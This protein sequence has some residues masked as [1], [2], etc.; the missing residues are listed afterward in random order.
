M[1]LYASAANHCREDSVFSR[2]LRGRTYEALKRY[3]DAQA[4]Y[5]RMV[6]LA[7]EKAESGC[8][9]PTSSSERTNRQAISDIEKA[10][11]LS[12]DNLPVQQR[13]L[14]CS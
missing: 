1:R 5:D 4:D 2:L 6:A 12:R 3:D 11:E 13:A 9:G 7:P 14:S 8:L 10:L